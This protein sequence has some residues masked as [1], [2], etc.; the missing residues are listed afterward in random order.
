MCG[1]VTELEPELVKS[2]NQILNLSKVGT[3]TLKNSYG[4]TTLI[5]DNGKQVKASFQCDP[6]T[7]IGTA[8]AEAQHRV[9]GKAGRKAKQKIC[10][11]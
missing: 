3:G 2:Q 4:S 11:D 9:R 8:D 5:M 1:L 6:G 7:F 10:S